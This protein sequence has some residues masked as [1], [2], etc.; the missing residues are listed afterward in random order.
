MYG[1]NA[2]LQIQVNFGIN[3]WDISKIEF[4]VFHNIIFLLP[5]A[6]IIEVKK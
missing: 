5:F 1:L 3:M 2:T 6:S 4:D